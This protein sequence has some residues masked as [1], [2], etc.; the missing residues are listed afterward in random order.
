MLRSL[1]GSEMCIRDRSSVLPYTAHTPEPKREEELLLH[2][3][4]IRALDRQRCIPILTSKGLEPARFTAL[5]DRH[6]QR[7]R[8]YDAR[9]TRRQIAKDTSTAQTRRTTLTSVRTSQF[10]S[11]HTMVG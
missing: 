9:A 1:V 11:R 4:R 5:C 6:P 10:T 7:E 2:E 8:W 3:S